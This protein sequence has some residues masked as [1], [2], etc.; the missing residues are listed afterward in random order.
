M[1]H[2][3]NT[4]AVMARLRSRGARI[5]FMD[6]SRCGVGARYP[7]NAHDPALHRP[8]QIL[9]KDAQGW[10]NAGLFRLNVPVGEPDHLLWSQGV[11]PAFA[12]R[13]EISSR[14]P[15]HGAVFPKPFHGDGAVI[16]TDDDFATRP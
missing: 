12:I 13:T 11:D 2:A 3:A 14:V 4:V 15:V 9:P 6:R 16:A 1:G 8:S 7:I 10:H 5:D